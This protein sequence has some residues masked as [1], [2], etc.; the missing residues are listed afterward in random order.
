MDIATG[1]VKKIIYSS[2]ETQ[3][4]TLA[5]K[6]GNLKVLLPTE[7]MHVE[8]RDHIRVKG[9][10]IETKYGEQFLAK[11]VDYT[12]VSHLMITDFI[13]ACVGVGKATSQRLIE[14]F[15]GNLIHLIEANEIEVLSKVP[16]I[17]R[18]LASTICNQWREQ[19][20]KVELIQFMDTVLSNVNAKNRQALRSAARKAFT[21]YQ[22]DTVAKLQEDPYRIWAFTSFT[23]ADCLAK[24]LNLK[25]SDPRR[26]ICAV[27]EILYR[28]LK[29]GSTWISLE[30]CKRQLI[31]LLGNEEA[32]E[33][34]LKQALRN[35][36]ERVIFTQSSSTTSLALSGSA[37][38]ENYVAEQLRSRLNNKIMEIQVSNEELKNYRFQN[39]FGLSDEQ[40]EA[41]KLILNNSVSLVS[42]GGGTGKTSVLY[43]AN[44]MI[45]QSGSD[46]L[47]IAL[48]GK[49]S[50]RLIQQTEDD[51][52][53]IAALLNRVEIEPNFLDNYRMPVVHIDEASMVDLQSMYRILSVFE[54]R[55][56]RLVFI[57]DWAQLAPVGI[58][59]IFHKLIK[60]NVVPR[61]ELTM[62]FRSNQGVQIVADAIKRGSEFAPSNDVEIISYE[63]KSELMAIVERQ[64]YLNTFNGADAHIIAARKSTVTEVNVKIFIEHLLEV[65]RLL[66]LL[67]SSEKAI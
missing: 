23:S 20:G 45:K 25:Q 31:T 9:N 28:Q 40:T 50:Q 14:A 61:I 34:A 43:C 58:G 48:S 44:D 37:I 65:E 6:Q 46:V 49:A 57:G 8:P 22:D 35:D 3:V 12:P 64:Y 51:A 67:H 33:K 36:R 5:T 7:D 18:A 54:D 4:I 10:L 55:P 30:G 16:M 38:M 59:L 21:V 15:P 26:L 47:Q 11:E 13:G 52:F 39:G 29:I 19:G 63:E 56:L 27:E 53:T 17:S 41:V 62:N 60:S 1:T 24:A 66:R 32:A 42:G 2:R